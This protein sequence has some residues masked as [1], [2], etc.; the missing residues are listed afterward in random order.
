MFD[1]SRTNSNSH[2]SFFFSLLE[3]FAE[4]HQ[5]LL[6]K[7]GLTGHQGEPDDEIGARRYIVVEKDEI[8]SEK[9]NFSKLVSCTIKSIKEKE[10]R[11]NL[12]HENDH[13]LI[14]SK[15]DLIK[16]QK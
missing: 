12:E 10:N 13:D 3:C 5:N 11:L 1:V 2:H 14:A 4:Q 8:E 7:Y 9:K 6:V 16:Y 15:D